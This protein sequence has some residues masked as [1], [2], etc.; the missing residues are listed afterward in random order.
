MRE[1]SSRPDRRYAAIPNAAMR[2]KSLSAEA[3]GTLAYLMTFSDEWRFIRDVICAD[4][5]FGKDKFQRVMGELREAGYV[6]LVSI[7][8]EGG[9]FAGTEW[10]IRD[11]PTESRK[12]PL[13]ADSRENRLPENPALSKKT[14]R[15]EDQSFLSKQTLPSTSLDTIQ[16]EGSA[17]GDL[18]AMDLPQSDPVSA[19][20]DFYNEVAERAGWPK[21]QVRSKSRVAAMKARLKDLGGLDG[22][23]VAMGKGEASDF[24]CNRSRTAFSAS[25]DFFLQAKSMISL[26]EGKYDNRANGRANGAHATFDAFSAAVARM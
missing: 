1:K 3:R 13:S 16:E 2:D 14:N 9:H 22:W 8:G 25:L 7:P 23:K 21:C 10:I 15:Q 26:M 12:N 20:F 24:L 17:R 5:G 18:F 19:A 11:D 4:M 6:D